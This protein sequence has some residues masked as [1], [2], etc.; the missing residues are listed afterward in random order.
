MPRRRRRSAIGAA[1]LLVLSLSVSRSSSDQSTAPF[2]VDHERMTLVEL[3]AK[4][5]YHLRKPLWTGAAAGANHL[6]LQAYLPNGF[7]AV[8]IA[9]D[10]SG[11]MAGGKVVASVSIP[12]S[13][14]EL[15]AQT[16]N[17]LLGAWHTGRKG[18]A[19]LFSA[20]TGQRRGALVFSRDVPLSIWEMDPTD[21]AVGL[22]KIV[23]GREGAAV[24]D[25]SF[26]H[27]FPGCPL[28]V[29]EFGAWGSTDSRDLAAFRAITPQPVVLFRTPRVAERLP[30][31]CPD[32]NQDATS[33]VV[34]FLETSAARS[35]DPALNCA[36]IEIAPIGA[37]TAT[38][39][40]KDGGMESLR[41]LGVVDGFSWCPAVFKDELRGSYGLLAYYRREVS[42]DLSDV[43]RELW[44]VPVSTTGKIL[45]T[46]AFRVHPSVEVELSPI[47]P[48][49]PS[50]DP[51]GEYLFFL[52]FR[53]G[54]NPAHVAH[55]PRAIHLQ[56]GAAR[57]SS[58]PLDEWSN[59]L[60][61]PL[62]KSISCSG[63]GAYLALVATGQLPQNP[64]I[65][66]DHAYVVPIRRP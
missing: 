40:F 53:P 36:R 21:Q 13:I 39:Q 2:S 62:N 59:V 55:L 25:M 63:D 51:T 66:Y 38:P 56:G 26:P 1:S 42:A 33:F 14:G 49:A 44:V 46:L 31:L 50:W 61:K 48:G 11:Q 12:A 47:D 60:S 20:N 16:A 52:D 34:A 5:D 10:V 29:S 43:R 24:V 37:L 65:H 23:E 15:G 28:V 19:L 3:S 58:W 27:T 18:P 45:S 7:R 64:E 32:P 9:P 54:T 41:A 4:G 30:Q 8:V 35:G 17:L 6:A 57:V 22:R